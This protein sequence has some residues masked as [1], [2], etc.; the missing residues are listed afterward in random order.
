[1]PAPNSQKGGPV[2]NTLTEGHMAKA[3][4]ST[5][6]LLV[7]RAEAARI[8][9]NCSTATIIRLQKDG[10]LRPVRL[11]PRKPTAQVYYPA[12]QVQAIAQ[13]K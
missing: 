1:M 13:G 7:S 6:Q 4:N 9:G 11:N 12:E 8:L 3:P 10:R 5:Q 2:T